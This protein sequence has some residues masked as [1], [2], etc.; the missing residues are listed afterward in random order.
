MTAMKIVVMGLGRTGTTALFFKLKQAMAADTY[1]LFEPRSFVAPPGHTPHVLAKVLIGHNRD[2]DI[3]GF[4]DFDKKLF[5]IRDP[6]DTLVSRVL[7]DIYNETTICTD[8]AKVDAFVSLLR[9]KETDPSST[10]LCDI[11]DLFDRM[12]RRPVLPRATRDAG[13]ALDFQRHHPDF[14]RYRYE[15]LVRAD[16]TAIESHVGFAVGP[17]VA[18]VSAE[19]GRVVRTK[20]HGDW[21]NWLTPADVDFFRPWFT[22]YLAYNAYPDDWTLPAQPR[23]PPEHG[24]AYVLRLVKERRGVTPAS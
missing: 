16:Y 15:D 22:P 20:K 12:S 23:I 6:R 21:R 11:I 14:F 4:Q 1:C 24:S 13:V 5:L 7:Y 2:V 3:S 19:F 17:D 10:P 8:E 9:R 18:T